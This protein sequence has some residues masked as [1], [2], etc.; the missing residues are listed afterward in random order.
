MTLSI[1]SL[2]ASKWIAFVALCSVLEVE[3]AAGYNT[4]YHR[5]VGVDS[6]T[7]SCF[8]SNLYYRN[9]KQ[10]FIY[11]ELKRTV[12]AW[13]HHEWTTNFSAGSAASSET[14]DPHTRYPLLFLLGYT[15][16]NYYTFVERYYDW[17]AGPMDPVV[18]V[19]PAMIP[20]DPCVIEATTIM[21][22]TWMRVD[23][24]GHWFVDYFYPIVRRLVQ[25]HLID[26]ENV[27]YLARQG[28]LGYFKHPLF[29]TFTPTR[30]KTMSLGG[31]SIFNCSTGGVCCNHTWLKFKQVVAGVGGASLDSVLD[32]HTPTFHGSPASSHVWETLRNILYKR[33]GTPLPYSASHK[34]KIV[35]VRRAMRRRL[36]NIE[37]MQECLS[38][39]FTNSVE[40]QDWLSLRTTKELL[41]YI[42][43]ISVMIT[44]QG[45]DSFMSV[46]LPNGATV[47]RMG[48]P[49][50]SKR[51]T[52][53]HA[54]DR[55]FS[56]ISYLHS[57][58][59]PLPPTAVEG[60]DFTVA[61]GDQYHFNTIADCER[62]GDNV[63]QALD[64]VDRF[65]SL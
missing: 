63:E 30:P 51:Q 55:F 43:S 41:S 18:V 2:S 28:G 24:F 45:T 42:S 54:W 27:Q 59:Y 31:D 25:F 5:C 37:E 16:G 10:Q 9:D 65:S 20:A 52:P 62:L 40:I 33:S 47:I 4:S 11:L 39:R 53:F 35:L 13:G 3:L 50:G 19:D 21:T 15:H 29:E 36:E 48:T 14:S 38:Q 57:L 23:H 61:G 34:G 17:F 22:D 6:L 60:K 8:F 1:G 26:K 64:K 49:I 32:E 56:E 44:S 7:R 46:L 58:F 12:K